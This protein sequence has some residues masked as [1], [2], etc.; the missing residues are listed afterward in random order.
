MLTPAKISLASFV[1][2]VI[3]AFY[4]PNEYLRGIFSRNE[5]TKCLIYLILT[6]TDSTFEIFVFLC[7]PED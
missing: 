2:D 1:Y 4:F 5:I 3:G 7:N 6:D